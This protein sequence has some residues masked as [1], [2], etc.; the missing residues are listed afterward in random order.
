MKKS[1]EQPGVY[2]IH[3]ISSLVVVLLLSAGVGYILYHNLNR[4]FLEQSKF[5]ERNVSFQRET[6]E[7][8]FNTMSRMIQGEMI[9]RNRQM[10][11]ETT[12]LEIENIFQVQAQIE[13]LIRTDIQNTLQ[14]LSGS[15]TRDVSDEGE[16]ASDEEEN[17]KL[18]CPKDR[19]YFVLDEKGEIRHY[20]G[21]EGNKEQLNRDTLYQKYD[22]TRIVNTMKTNSESWF[23]YPTSGNTEDKSKQPA[24][25]QAIHIKHTGWILCFGAY[26][27]SFYTE[28]TRN[29]MNHL[30]TLSR[31]I[32]TESNTRIMELINAEGGDGFA[33]I[34]VDQQIP[35]NNGKLISSNEIDIH[36]YPFYSE[37]LKEIRM[38]GEAYIRS[39]EQRK[40]GQKPE[41]LLTYYKIIPETN[42]IIARSISFNQFNESA[43]ENKEYFRKI[44]FGTNDQPLLYDKNTIYSI[45]RSDYLKLLLLILAYTL[46]GIALFYG[47]SRRIQRAYSQ[48]QEEAEKQHGE[49]TKANQVMHQ[50][51]QQRVRAER[52][53]AELER[54]TSALAMAVTASHEINQ[55]LMI[56]KGNL[57]MYMMTIDLDSLDAGQIKRLN[58]ISS[59]LERIQDILKKFHSADAIRFEEYSEGTQMVVF[60]QKENIDKHSP[61]IDG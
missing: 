37:M 27:Q 22:V 15:I 49:L 61:S 14:M 18:S 36:E 42:W 51:F 3:M 12:N 38:T 31:N 43:E 6:F 54:K 5:F 35:R 41:E 39:V 59:S 11:K 46:T 8:R 21:G 26:E 52:E 25:A 4:I 29:L 34:L 20:C 55:P 1:L 50:E 16:N 60:D 10:L 44:V 45:L 32:E 13:R 47:I 48:Y 17:L 33:R 53:K 23:H 7:K 40:M 2:K 57:E 9:Q 56:L 19:F 28:L 58:N 24:L 30:G